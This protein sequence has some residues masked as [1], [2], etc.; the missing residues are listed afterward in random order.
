MCFSVSFLNTEKYCTTLLFSC[1]K[2]TAM[3]TTHKKIINLQIQNQEII[4]FYI[5]LLKT[6]LI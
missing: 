1:E 2:H 4:Y 5:I 3:Q 6:L